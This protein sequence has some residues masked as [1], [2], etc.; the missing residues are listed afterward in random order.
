MADLSIVS[1][2][3][4]FHYTFPMQTKEDIYKLKVPLEI[5]FTDS[6]AELV[7]RLVTSLKL[8]AYAEEGRCSINSYF[9]NCQ[10][11]QS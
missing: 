11:L 3:I 8:P 2:Q 5:P 10:T 4:D 7:Q 1:K 6:T 9:T